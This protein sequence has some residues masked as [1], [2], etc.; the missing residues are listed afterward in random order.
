MDEKEAIGV[1]SIGQLVLVW[2]VIPVVVE[3]NYL[4]LFGGITKP[5]A[6]TLFVPSVVVSIVWYVCRN[7]KWFKKQLYF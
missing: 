2:A 3:I 1:V 7:R 5:M 6:W 4:I